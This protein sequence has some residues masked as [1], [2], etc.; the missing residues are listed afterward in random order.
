MTGEEIHR[1][2]VFH[3]DEIAEQLTVLTQDFPQDEEGRPVFDGS[4]LSDALKA[5]L[6]IESGLTRVAFK[7]AREGIT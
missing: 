5:L 4:D 7:L 3:A 2:L 6:S 1:W